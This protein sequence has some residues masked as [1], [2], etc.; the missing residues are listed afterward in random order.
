MSVFFPSV[1]LEAISNKGKG[2]FSGEFVVDISERFN[3]KGRFRFKVENFG[4]GNCKMQIYKGGELFLRY[5]QNAKRRKHEQCALEQ[6]LIR[7][8]LDTVLRAYEG[9]LDT[10]RNAL[11]KV[12]RFGDLVSVSFA[13][14][15]NSGEALVRACL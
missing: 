8:S 5:R 2:N 6:E 12:Q 11:V 7:V 13:A 9:K 3:T 1:R 4:L 15:D 10:T 14:P